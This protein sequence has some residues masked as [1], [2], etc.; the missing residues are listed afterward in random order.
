MRRNAVCKFKR[1]RG[2]FPGADAAS[3]LS[4]FRDDGGSDLWHL[5]GPNLARDLSGGKSNSVGTTPAGAK[6]ILYVRES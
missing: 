5:A 6:G 1:A 3:I 4:L 2:E